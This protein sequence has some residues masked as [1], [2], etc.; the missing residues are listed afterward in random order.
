M[1]PKKSRKAAPSKKT[2][3]DVAKNEQ[4]KS[5]DNAKDEEQDNDASSQAQAG[6]KRKEAPT[7]PE[8]HAKSAKTTTSTN[9]SQESL[10]TYLLSPASLELCRNKISDPEGTTSEDDQKEYFSTALLTPFEH[11]LCA[12]ILSRPLSHNLGQRT[13]RT[14]LNEPWG[15][16]NAR[17]ILEA[18]KEGDDG[19]TER[20][21]AMEEARTQHRQKTA[22]ELADMATMVEEEG[23]DDGSGS[24]KGLL[25]KVEGEGMEGRLRKEVMKIKGVGKTGADIFLR[26]VQGCEGWEGIGWF[27]DGKTREALESVGLPGEGE[28]LRKVVEGMGGEGQ[29]VRM[30]FVVVLERVLGISLEGKL[31]ELTKGAEAQ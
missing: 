20:V 25:G 7:S 8:P 3:A 19:K 16:S 1:P 17:T 29:D 30:D 6:E 11:L 28:A 14:V 21:H 2:D 13:I 18:G 27:V 12:V 31:E 26:R 9:P 5:D 22:Q 24:M 10:I 23:W 4:S 15:W